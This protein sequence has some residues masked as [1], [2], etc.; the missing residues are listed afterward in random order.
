MISQ[1]CSILSFRV[2][3]LILG[4]SYIN[5]INTFDPNSTKGDSEEIKLTLYKLLLLVLVVML[6]VL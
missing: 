1:K 3:A 2:I 5:P 6:Q 4:I